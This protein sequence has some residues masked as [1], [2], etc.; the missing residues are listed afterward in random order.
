MCTVQRQAKLKLLAAHVLLQAHATPLMCRS[1]LQRAAEL[2]RASSRLKQLPSKQ[3]RQSH[4]RLR[5]LQAQLQAWRGLAQ[6]AMT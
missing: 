5:E 1:A 6:W 2:V 3:A 4:S